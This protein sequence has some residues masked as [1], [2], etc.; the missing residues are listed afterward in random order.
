MTALTLACEFERELVV[1]ELLSRGADAKN[2][3]FAGALPIDIT[4]SRSISKL[5]IDATRQESDELL[6]MLE[7]QCEG[8][9]EDYGLPPM[10]FAAWSGQITNLLRLLRAGHDVDC[11]CP[12]D[13]TPLHTATDNDQEA[14][15][16]LLLERGANK[17]ARDRDGKTPLHIAAENDSP[18]LAELLLEMG[19]DP[20]HATDEFWPRT[21]LDVAKDLG[22]K[23]VCDVILK[24][25]G[26]RILE[27]ATSNI[28]IALSNASGVG[29]NDSAWNSP[30]ISRL[31]SREVSVFGTKDVLVLLSPRD[32]LLLSPRVRVG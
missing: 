18:H 29:Q 12:K 5:L 15:I 31:F 14:V 30:P 28:S 20:K 8:E 13:R 1:L 32:R 9:D 6:S 17:D 4:K 21:A 10:H 23:K 19:A 2:R 22:H 24:F 16:A 27:R 25:A 11:R 7:A 3:D 26:G